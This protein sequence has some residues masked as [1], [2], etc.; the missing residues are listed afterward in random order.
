MRFNVQT[1]VLVIGV[2]ASCILSAPVP[3]DSN[4]SLSSTTTTTSVPPTNTPNSF[5]NSNNIIGPVNNNQ[6]S[7]KNNNQN[8]NYG[9]GDLIT[10]PVEIDRTML[11]ALMSGGSAN[12]NIQ[13]NVVSTSNQLP[14]NAIPFNQF[15]QANGGNIPPPNANNVHVIQAGS[16]PPSPKQALVNTG[17]NVDNPSPT[18]ASSSTSST[19]TSTIATSTPPPP[20][21]S[22][23][24]DSGSGDEKPQKRQELQNRNSLH[25]HNTDVNDPWFG[26]ACA[27]RDGCT[28]IPQPGGGFVY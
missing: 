10:I 4:Q 22:D 23:D 18:P 8:N 19:S 21:P 11:Q 27:K 15:V 12:N 7:N 16:L 17:N 6:N 20:P 26:D 25:D 13:K 3:D 24:S 1:S 5:S 9:N 28:G 14:P 2:A